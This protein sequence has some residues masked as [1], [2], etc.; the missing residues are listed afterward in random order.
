M[1]A[2]VLRIPAGDDRLH[3]QIGR[4]AGNV[5]VVENA[6]PGCGLFGPYVDL[7]IGAYI[8]RIRFAP[9]TPLAGSVEF[10]ISAEGGAV[11]IARRRYDLGESG[12]PQ[13]GLTL[14][15]LLAAPANGCELRLFCDAGVSATIDRVEI[16][17][18][19]GELAAA[20]VPR[21]EA[22]TGL[23]T[24]TV[25]VLQIG[26][27]R[28]TTASGD[29]PCLRGLVAVRARILSVEPWTAMRVE[30]E[31]AR[32]DR[33]VPEMA[34]ALGAH[35]EEA[36]RRRDLA[37][38]LIEHDSETTPH[39]QA[40]LQQ[41]IFNSWF[42]AAPLPRGFARL[43][44]GFETSTGAAKVHE[45]L[46]YIDGEVS[47]DGNCL[48]AALT[49][50]EDTIDSSAEY[51]VNAQ[52]SAVHPARRAL[53]EA[54][55]RRVL[56]MEA[57]ALGDFVT[58]VPA[59]KRLRQLLPGAEFIG[60]LSAFNHELGESSGLFERTIRVEW[61]YDVV[62]KSRVLPVDRQIEVRRQLRECRPEL[63]IDLSPAPDMR[64]LLQLSGAPITVGF[65]PREFPWLSVA[66]E[67]QT[68]NT[69]S[70]G[71]RVSQ[72]ARLLSLVEALGALLR[73]PVVLVPP[74]AE[75]RRSLRR[76]GL[77]AAER[78]VLLNTGARWVVNRWPLARF[79]QLARLIIDD[80][81]VTIVL[82]LDDVSELAEVE[83]A[84]LPPDRVR[85]FVAL[86]FAEFDALLSHC[87]V[88][89]AND[90]GPKHLAALRGRK[91]V[92]VHTARLDWRE[93]GQEGDG[94]IVTRDVPCA[95]CGIVEPAAC[96]KALAFLT[97][98]Q[99]EEV[100]AAARQLIFDQS[101]PF[102]KATG[103]RNLAARVLEAV[104]ARLASS[105][106]ISR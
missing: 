4:C 10:N 13:D 96:G 99:P 43:T 57:D 41:Y 61:L 67:T 65:G 81:D 75:T 30:V 53:F 35:R 16:E 11:V 8:G 56:V 44:L 48:T 58:A 26:R 15:F 84:V 32:A 46:V 2:P 71:A 31:G 6:G 40:G 24:E 52:P 79:L 19:A 68:R 14:E 104:L 64:P 9:G 3:T 36:L 69:L 54:P 12:R 72:A 86:P 27:A 25:E 93:W 55:P 42:D 78:F 106:T 80:S 102:A 82:M 1:E 87:L 97:D 39:P 73:P 90:T 23:A 88:L 85:V 7:P 89:V 21:D 101:A 91:V 33:V 74:S 29:V 47:S 60:L 92:S 83:A 77:A 50:V 59:I 70:G 95:G 103:F 76:L 34:P 51:Q 100:W 5:I 37:G 105:V 45:E 94:L 49:C 66:I 38:H 18:N 22:E 17:D 62:R 98:I 20:L 63:A 28:R